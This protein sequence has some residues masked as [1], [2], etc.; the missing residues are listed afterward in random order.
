VALAGVSTILL[1]VVLLAS[2][3]P[4]RRAAAVHPVEALRSE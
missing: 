2:V 1:G 3:V 4:A